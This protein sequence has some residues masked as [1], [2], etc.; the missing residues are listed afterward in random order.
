MDAPRLHIDVDGT[1]PTVLLLHGFGGSARNFGPQMRALKDRYR[2]VRYDARG[3]ARSEMPPDPEAYTPET[4]VDDMRRVADE[5][6]ADR[7]VVGGLSMGAGV[8]LRFALAYPDRVRALMLCAFPAGADDPDGFAGKALRFAETIEQRGP[9]A[10]GEAY[11]WGPTTK[12]DRSAVHFV[13]QGFLEHPPHGLALT[14]RGLIAKQPSVAAMRTDLATVRC[15]TLV[16]VGSEDGPSL[17]ACRLLAA[18]LPRACLVV[19]PGAGHVVNLQKPDE[20][21]V[22]MMK[23]LD[24]LAGA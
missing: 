7:A 2:V 11:V 20:V 22:A 4:F 14:L 5:V 3:H 1:G 8:S 6:G 21:S 9:E 24:G 23:F 18:T 17:G 16:V 19:I 13:R 12:L 15:P 10:A